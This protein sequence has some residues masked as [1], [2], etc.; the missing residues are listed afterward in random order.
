EQISLRARSVAVAAAFDVM[1][2]GRPY[3]AAKSPEEARREI[4]RMAGKQF[5]PAV[6]RALMNVSLG[7]LRWSMG[8]VAWLGQIPFFLDR[9]GRDFVT[10]T[11]AAALTAVSMLGGLVGL[12]LSMAPAEAAVTREAAPSPDPGAS[13]TPPP[14][15]P[16]PAVAAAA[17]PGPAPALAD[18]DPAHCND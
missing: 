8:P 9:L 7:R 2:T 6:A 5:D 10:V 12:P 16:G 11:S 15:A 14:Q 3:Q 1:T 17:A 13:P 4:A 18:A